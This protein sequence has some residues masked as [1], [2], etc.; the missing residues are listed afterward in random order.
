[1][2]KVF[3]TKDKVEAECLAEKL[4]DECLETKLEQNAG[5][6]ELYVDENV[7]DEALLQ[8][9]NLE[10]DLPKMVSQNKA[11]S[12]KFQDE[13]EYEKSSF[14]Y[15]VEKFFQLK[16]KHL[17][18]ISVVFAFVFVLPFGLPMVISSIKKMDSDNIKITALL[19]AVAFVISQ[20]ILISNRYYQDIKE[21][22]NFFSI[23][24]GTWKDPDY[25]KIGYKIFHF[26]LAILLHLVCYI[27]TIS[28][29]I[30]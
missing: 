30:R 2:K 25:S 3:E 13:D 17:L 10:Y 28:V 15:A 20:A 5:K 11:K 18:L 14:L 1:M 21:L 22:R 6:Y 19:F 27:F 12:N 23:K 8:I 9:E 4:E 16:Y 29:M 7:Y 26:I 24:L